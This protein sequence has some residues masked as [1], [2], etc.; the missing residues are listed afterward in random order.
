MDDEDIVP[1][2][3]RGL[4]N[5]GPADI[6]VEPPNVTELRLRELML[7]EGVNVSISCF[8]G[9]GFERYESI[10]EYAYSGEFQAFLYHVAQEAEHRSLRA[11]NLLLVDC[12]KADLSLLRPYR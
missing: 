1:P 6:G 9:K 11:S 3:K 12:G 10:L 8:E 2:A 4:S 7:P 5:I